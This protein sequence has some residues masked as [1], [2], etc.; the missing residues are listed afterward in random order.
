MT[1]QCLACEIVQLQSLRAS[2]CELL[3]ACSA[4]QL[5]SVQVVGKSYGAMVSAG[6]CAAGL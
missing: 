3:L 1:R 2:F 4:Q 6:L 5:T